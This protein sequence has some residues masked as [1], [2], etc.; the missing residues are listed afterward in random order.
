M[1]EPLFTFINFM[2]VHKPLNKLLSQVV[3][4]Y[5]ACWNVEEQAHGVQYRTISTHK[6]TT[7]Y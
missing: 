4:P 6:D 7:V 3:I 2:S 5:V 1:N